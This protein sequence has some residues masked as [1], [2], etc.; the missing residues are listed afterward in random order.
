VPGQP[1][2]TI[3]LRATTL[4]VRARIGR[5]GIRAS[6]E[7]EQRH[8]RYRVPCNSVAAR[9]RRRATW[10]RRVPAR[11]GPSEA[12]NARLGKRG[13][14]AASTSTNAVRRFRPAIQSTPARAGTLVGRGLA[15]GGSRGCL[16]VVE[17]PLVAAHPARRSGSSRCSHAAPT[18]LSRGARATF[19]AALALVLRIGTIAVFVAQ[20]GHERR[21]CPDPVARGRSV[22]S[23]SEFFRRRGVPSVSLARQRTST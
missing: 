15:V 12:A 10:E 17:R 18:C 11:R 6:A 19:L 20:R 1:D 22:R 9:P 4:S 7:R 3:R 2:R 8:R 21:S 13:L 5:T 23:P 14:R 16:A